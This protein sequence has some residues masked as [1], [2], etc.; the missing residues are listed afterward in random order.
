ML[1]TAHSASTAAATAASSVRA[2]G[3][4]L[5]TTPIAGQR[6]LGEAVQLIGLPLAFER[7]LHAELEASQLVECAVGP[8]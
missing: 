8:V 4:S 2:G 1:R 5:P 7:K 6:A 3:L